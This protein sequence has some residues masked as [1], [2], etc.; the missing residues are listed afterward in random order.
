MVRDGRNWVEP[1]EVETPVSYF[2]PDDWNALKPFL[3]SF[4]ADHREEDSPGRGRGGKR[5]GPT[6]VT[7]V[8]ISSFFKH[9]HQPVPVM[10]RVRDEDEVSTML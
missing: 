5:R 3:P 8:K 10:S 9:Y 7:T 1:K 6:W 4:A 2:F